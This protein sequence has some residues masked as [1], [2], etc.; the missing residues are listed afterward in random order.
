MLASRHRLRIG[1]HELPTVWN[2][3]RNRCGDDCTLRRSTHFSRISPSA[4]GK[5]CQ[6]GN[7]FAIDFLNLIVYLAHRL[8]QSGK[9]FRTGGSVLSDC[10]RWSDLT[11][12][13]PTLLVL[14]DCFS[15][16]S[17]IMPGQ[18]SD[19]DRPPPP[20][21][22]HAYTLRSLGAL[23]YSAR[24]MSGCNLLPNGGM[25]TCRLHIEFCFRRAPHGRC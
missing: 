8:A 5:V 7:R 13:S 3:A 18:F 14:G 25:A 2:Q 1:L 6:I 24:Q 12:V 20:N 9:L 22:P 23:R 17:G 11:I 15:R 19:R 21:R 4:G 16:R 10:N